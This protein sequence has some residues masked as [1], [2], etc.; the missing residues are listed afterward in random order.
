MAGSL[1]AENDLN[2]DIIRRLL[3]PGPKI[4]FVTRRP[5]DSTRPRI[6]NDAKLMSA[7]TSVIDATQ[8]D[9]KQD[10]QSMTTFKRDSAAPMKRMRKTGRP[11]IL[12]L[13]GKAEV[14]TSDAAAWQKI[15]SRAESTES[16]RRGLAQA[17]KGQGRPVDEVFD[18]LEA[19][20]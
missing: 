14:V 12:T 10:I 3:R 11:L 15:A 13:K 17:K 2:R 18:D 6:I 19:Q 5:T 8:I 9:V 7:A 1:L 20:G 16:I 4:D